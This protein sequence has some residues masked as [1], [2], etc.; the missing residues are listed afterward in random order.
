MRQWKKKR[1]VQCTGQRPN[2]HGK[3]ETKAGGKQLQMDMQAGM[4]MDANC[5]LILATVETCFK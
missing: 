1:G 2:C 3:E 5:K 4:R